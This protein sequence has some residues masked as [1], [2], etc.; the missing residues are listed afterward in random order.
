MKET[1]LIVK[2]TYSQ[3]NNLSVIFLSAIN[4]SNINKLKNVLFNKSNKIIKKL[5][6][7]KLN[8]V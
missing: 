6:T 2:R 1:K 5:P 3:T 4:K 7:G 8:L